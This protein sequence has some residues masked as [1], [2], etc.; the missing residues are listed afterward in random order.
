MKKDLGDAPLHLG[1]FLILLLIRL[2][3]G[4]ALNGKSI[5]E[6]FSLEL[7]TIGQIFR[8]MSAIFLLLSFYVSTLF[9]RRHKWFPNAYIV[10]E[11]FSIII[12]ISAYWDAKE[13]F[14]YS[15]PMRSWLPIDWFRHIISTVESEYGYRLIITKKTEWVN[16]MNLSVKL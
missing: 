1:G 9:S 6:I 8:I 3:G 11:V 14:L 4:I 2:I 13:R 15:Q 10:M 16:V 7:D 5:L 12:Y